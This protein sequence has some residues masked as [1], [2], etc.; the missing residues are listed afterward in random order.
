[1]A[2][3]FRADYTWQLGEN[4]TDNPLSQPGR[5]TIRILFLAA[6][7]GY[8]RRWPCLGAGAAAPLPSVLQN[9]PWHDVH[10]FYNY[11]HHRVDWVFG[12]RSFNLAQVLENANDVEGA[13]QIV[14][15]A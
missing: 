15:G 10:I 5:K 14:F 1:M 3:N 9:I 4:G 2:S 11:E 7:D 13:Q 6:H 8:R 12:K